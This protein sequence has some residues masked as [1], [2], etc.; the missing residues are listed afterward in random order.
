LHRRTTPHSAHLRDY[1]KQISILRQRHP[2]EGQSLDVL[3]WVHRRGILHAN[4]ILPDGTRAMI[5]AAWTDYVSLPTTTAERTAPSAPVTATLAAVADLLH[6]HTVVAPL[7]ARIQSASTARAKQPE[8][9]PNAASTKAAGANK[10]S[11]FERFRF[12]KMV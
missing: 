10:G 11:H 1:P 7:L 8:V 3:A 12:G 9:E 5:P 4:A 2:F 6:A